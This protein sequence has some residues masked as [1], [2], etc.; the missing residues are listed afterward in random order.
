M[1]V[2]A[3]VIKQQNIKL[4]KTVDYIKEEKLKK[5]FLAPINHIMIIK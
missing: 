5:G 3:K 4:N 1:E 2:R